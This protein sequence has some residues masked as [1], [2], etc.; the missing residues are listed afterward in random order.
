[1]NAD[2]AALLDALRLRFGLGRQAAERLAAFLALLENE[3]RAPSAVTAA[4]DAL[5]VHVADSLVA[6]EVAPLASATSIADL[7]SG[8]GV[9]GLVLAIALPDARVRLVESQRRKTQFLLLAVER[10]GLRNVEVV[11]DRV[12]AWTHAAG[13]LDVVT[14]RAVAPAPVVLEYAAPLLRLGGTLVDWRGRRDTREEAAADRASEI[15]G[16]ERIETRHVRP[17]P[18][19]AHRHLHVY[20]KQAPTPPGF[21]RRP[22]VASKRPLGRA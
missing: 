2:D 7:G 18:A 19:A 21:P 6:L 15:L 13:A 9:P 16:L 14:A 12:E 8:A 10:L 11:H 4:A 17:F 20:R 1:M 5:D 3:P 22:G